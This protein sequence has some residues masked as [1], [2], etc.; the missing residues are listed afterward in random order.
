MFLENL[1]LILPP[2]SSLSFPDRSTACRYIDSIHD[3]LCDTITSALDSVCGRRSPQEDDYT[4]DFRTPE[5][6]ATFN[7]KEYL[8]KKWRKARGL[9]SLSLWIQHQEAHAAL[10]RLVARRRRETWNLFC[11]SMAMGDYT[12][13]IAKFSKIRKHR[14]IKTTFSTS[15]GPQN[16]ADVMAQHL[17]QIFAGNL[18]PSHNSTITTLAHPFDDTN[19][20]PIDIDGINTAIKELLRSKAHGVDHLTVEMLQPLAEA[21]TPVLLYIFRLCWQWSYTHLSWRVTQVIPIHKKGS[22]SDPGNF[23]PISLTS[24]FRKI[25]EKCLYTDLEYQSPPLD[26]DQGGFRSSQSTLDQAL[27]LVETCSILRRKLKTTPILAFLDIESAYD[28]EKH[29]ITKD[30]SLKFQKYN[31]IK[32]SAVARQSSRS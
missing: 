14:K 18:L 21:L 20:C 4:K 7:R 10:H 17:E 22:V 5:M 11:E 25:L 28:T 3:Q 2:H 6:T 26:I 1:S 12:K 27:C 31:G 24:I 16:S 32:K 30:Q 9:N 13:A 23:R 19:T 29:N 8:Y 15:E